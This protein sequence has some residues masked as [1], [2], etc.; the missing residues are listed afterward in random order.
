MLRTSIFILFAFMLSVL[1]GTSGIAADEIDRLYYEMDYDSVIALLEEKPTDSL[2]LNDRLVLLESRARSGHGHQAL[3]QIDGIVDLFPRN[4]TIYTA[5]AIVYHSVG[6]FTKA[7]EFIKWALRMNPDNFKALHEHAMLSLHTGDC[8]DADSCLSEAIARRP[9]LESTTFC[10]WTASEIYRACL[11]AESSSIIYK[12]RAER[13]D[14]LGD[15]A[16]AGNCRKTSE[17]HSQLIGRDMFSIETDSDKVVLPLVDFEEGS[18]HKCLVLTIDGKDYL[19]LLDTGNAAAW[20]I[21]SNDLRRKLIS[22][23]GGFTSSRTGLDNRGT[24]SQN[25]VTDSIVIG[26]VKFRNLVGLFFR[27]PSEHYYDANLNP[28]WIRDHV[29]TIDLARNELILRSKERF[30]S[31]MATVPRSSITRLPCYGYDRPY[32]PVMINSSAVGMALIETGAQDISL[33]REFADFM[34]L[35]YSER[36]I[37]DTDG[38]EHIVGTAEVQAQVGEFSFYRPSAWIWP[39]RFHNKITGVYDHIMIGPLA[40][41]G[42][43]VLSFDP[44]ARTAILQKYTE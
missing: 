42:Q 43:F 26:N 18:S 39:M 1:A 2:V 22:L 32:V 6:R 7:Q 3:A 21:H 28:F 11:F 31:D 23:S 24:A 10:T 16:E 25:I 19:V 17:M 35:Q 15:R 8:E 41:E 30:E 37:T 9:D 13:F 5:A 36:I 27:K 38:K 29:V 20:T 40:L 14:S 34:G 12:D 4:D 33:R 44:F